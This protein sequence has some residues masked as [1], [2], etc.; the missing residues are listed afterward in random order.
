MPAPP[1]TVAGTLLQVAKDFR[2]R[3]DTTN[4]IAKLQQAT[5]LDPANPE[6]LAELALT[7]ESMQLFDRSNEV[8]RR[9]QSLGP[10]SGP[11]FALADL[12]L[13]VGVPSR[14]ST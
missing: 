6:I 9:L 7:Y 10:A 8:W 13:Q 3:G 12:K 14:P 4:A 2:E 5:S 11:L 1:T